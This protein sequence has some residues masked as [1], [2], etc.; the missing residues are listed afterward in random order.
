M[1]LLGRL[2]LMPIALLFAIPAGGVA[3]LLAALVDPV[4]KGLGTQLVEAG[5][6]SLA[7]GLMA[8][9]EP[10]V[11]LGSVAKAGALAFW[12]L[13]VPPAFVGLVG[14]VAGFRAFLWYAGATGA[15]TAAMPWL[16]RAG[17]RGATVAELHVTGVLFAA[18]AVAGAAYWLIAGSSAGRRRREIPAHPTAG[19]PAAPA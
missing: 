6:V 11:L 17:I 7:D 15:L 1:R 12:L 4:V 3:L 9:D 13:V 14:E 18:G 5:L 2:I 16:A 8:F 10:E 19:L